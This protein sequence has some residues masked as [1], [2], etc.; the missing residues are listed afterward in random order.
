[1]TL[2]EAKTAA[3]A[4]EDHFKFLVGARFV[5][6]NEYHWYRAVAAV[7]GENCRRNDDTSH[8]QALAADRTIGEAH[9]LYIKALHKFY[10]MRDGPKGVLGGRGL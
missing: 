7:R 5:G 1:M 10:V 3:E 4:A 9:D 8:D 2:T 6:M